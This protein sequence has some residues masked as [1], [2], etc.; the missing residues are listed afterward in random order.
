MKNKKGFTLIE[1]IVVVVILAVLLAV[2]VPSVLKYINEADDAKYMTQA[3][4]VY[5]TMSI[6]LTKAL[7]VDSDHS[8]TSKEIEDVV[9]NIDFSDIDKLVA[10]S[11]PGLIRSGNE[12]DNI[13]SI[14]TIDSLPSTYCVVFGTI[15]HEV[16][17]ERCA[18]V[19]EN[20]SIEILV[21]VPEEFASTLVTF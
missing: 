11:T 1:I 8:L 5:S 14:V 20:E 18:I 6:E 17:V 4:A 3:R 12:Y 10:V 13:T 19:K 15:T 16:N 21:S 9:S 7:S 2:A